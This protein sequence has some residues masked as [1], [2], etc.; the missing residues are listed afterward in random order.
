MINIKEIFDALNIQHK[1][2]IVKISEDFPHYMPNSDIDIFCL[3]PGKLSQTIIHLMHKYIDDGYEINIDEQDNYIQVDLLKDN[4]LDIK[5]D[6]YKSLPSYQNVSIRDSL[7]DVVVEGSVL[8]RFGKSAEDHVD[9]YV[10]NFL[11]DLLIRYI[12]YHEWY[13]HRGDKLRHAEY[14]ENFLKND[15]ERRVFFDRVHYYTKIPL[16]T[17]EFEL[18]ENISIWKAI[19]QLLSKRRKQKRRDRKVKKKNQ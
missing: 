6:I 16:L 1:Y 17:S 3:N 12:E 13:P 4:K 7:Y 10:P 14:I 8:K 19:S 2:S 15:H 18:E 9:V 11:D 5:W